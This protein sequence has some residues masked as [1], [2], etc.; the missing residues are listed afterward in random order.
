MIKTMMEKW[1]AEYQFSTDH[2]IHE[3][4]EVMG[5]VADDLVTPNVQETD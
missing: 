1:P 3:L 5:I 4:L 2:E